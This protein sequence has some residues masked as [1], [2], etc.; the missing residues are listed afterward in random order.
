MI[1]GKNACSLDEAGDAGDGAVDF[2]GGRAVAGGDGAA[3]ARRR[4][5]DLAEQRAVEALLAVEVVVEHRLVHAG[6]AGDAIDAGAG[7]A[8]L[9][10]LEGGGGEDAVGRD[11]RP[12][13]PYN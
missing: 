6:A 3:G 4:R 13:E 11:A 10:E 8:A 1:A 2:L 7:E 9:G 12:G 5:E